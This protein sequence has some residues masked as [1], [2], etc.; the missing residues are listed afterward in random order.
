M[1]NAVNKLF[2]QVK[3]MHFNRLLLNTIISIT[4]LTLNTFEQLRLCYTHFYDEL[5]GHLHSLLLLH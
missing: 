3:R 2:S 4:T 1:R 5:R